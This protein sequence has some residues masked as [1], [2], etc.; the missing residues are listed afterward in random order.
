M[1]AAMAARMALT[2]TGDLDKKTNAEGVLREIM[3]STLTVDGQDEPPLD[4]GSSP[5]LLARL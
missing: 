2:L 1:S 3:K 5:L 4:F